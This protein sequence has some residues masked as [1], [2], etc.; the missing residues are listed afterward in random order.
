MPRFS[1]TLLL[2]LVTATVLAAPVDRTPRYLASGFV[3]DPAIA[4]DGDSFL[5]VWRDT[6]DGRAV[7]RARRIQSDATLSDYTGFILGDAPDSISAPAVAWNGTTYLVAWRHDRG[8]AT[9]VVSRDG[10]VLATEQH[11]GP[12]NVAGDYPL[13]LAWNGRRHIIIV[14]VDHR[15]YRTLLE[16]RSGWFPIPGGAGQGAPAV[17]SNGRD[18]LV[19]WSDFDRGFSVIEGMRISDAGAPLDA[20][21]LEIGRTAIPGESYRAEA[22]FPVIAWDGARYVVVWT[23]AGVRARSVTDSGALSAEQ[24]LATSGEHAAVTPVSGGLALAWNVL[25]RQQFGATYDLTLAVMRGDALDQ[26]TTFVADYALSPTRPALAANDNAIAAIRPDQS[27]DSRKRYDV[28][29]A[30]VNA[31]LANAKPL[32][33]S[34]AAFGQY[35]PRVLTSGNG[36]LV[37]WAESVPQ[38]SIPYSGLGI[39]RNFAAPV[40]LGATPLAAPTMLSEDIYGAAGST[41]AY[42]AGRYLLVWTTFEPPLTRTIGTLVDESGKVVKPPFVIATNTYGSFGHNPVVVSDGAAFVIV[43]FEET[44]GSTPFAITAQRVATDGTLGE[45]RTLIDGLSFAP[46]YLKG[47]LA[48]GRLALAWR[49]FNGSELETIAEFTSDLSPIRAPFRVALPYASEV[50][51]APDATFVA[52]F[53]SFPNHAEVAV[54]R[55]GAVS[56]NVKVGTVGRVVDGSATWTGS[57]LVTAWTEESDGGSLLRLARI[58]AT[59]DIRSVTTLAQSREL[60]G[61]VAVAAAN[62]QLLLAFGRNDPNTAYGDANRIQLTLDPMPRR[63][64]TTH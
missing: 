39:S 51:V 42:A 60:A 48:F 53:A 4:T 20:A 37:T 15:L 58:S 23:T 56:A 26:Q 13:A 59:G 12:A 34:I 52:S 57:E 2:A 10:R 45:R 41:G 18:F 33:L 40:T 22:S 62:G 63:R 9:A 47:S 31:P 14:D 29:L 36:F 64:S 24:L 1:A 30:D 7:I 6:R 46:Y 25:H 35:A 17:A 16:Q 38:F 43:D 21:A 8:F 54:I 49:E 28:L 50:V 44:S 19:V 61:G 27:I 55:N 11:A 3:I 5:A 32:F